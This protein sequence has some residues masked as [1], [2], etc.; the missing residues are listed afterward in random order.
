MSVIT[1]N[2][3]CRGNLKHPVLITQI[4]YTEATSSHG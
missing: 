1:L 3:L 4:P 2:E